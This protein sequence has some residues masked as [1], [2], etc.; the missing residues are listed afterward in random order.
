MNR[1]CCCC[2]FKRSSA[3][4]ESN[5]KQPPLSPASARAVAD[6]ERHRRQKWIAAQ[7]V[8]NE[9]SVVI[10]SKAAGRRVKAAA[11]GAASTVSTAA[12]DAAARAVEAGRATRATATAVIKHHIDS[13]AR[14]PAPT[15][16]TR[17]NPLSRAL[18]IATTALADGLGMDA[19]DDDTTQRT[20]PGPLAPT[21]REERAVDASRDFVGLRVGALAGAAHPDEADDVLG[22]LQSGS[23]SEPDTAGFV[24][25]RSDA[26]RAPRWTTRWLAL[27]ADSS[28]CMRWAATAA[29]AA[30]RLWASS[31][32][33]ALRSRWRRNRGARSRSCRACTRTATPAWT[34]GGCAPT[35]PRRRAWLRALSTAITRANA[36]D[37]FGERRA[38]RRTTVRG[39]LHHCAGPKERW[40]RRW[41]VLDA[42]TS[43]L[44]L[45]LD[46]YGHQ[47]AATDANVLGW[48][49]RVVNRHEQTF[50]VA[51]TDAQCAWFFQPLCERESALE[52]RARDA[53][54][55]AAVLARATPWEI[56]NGAVPMPFRKDARQ[57]LHDA[58]AQESPDLRQWIRA[59]REATRQRTRR[60]G[61]DPSAPGARARGGHPEKGDPEEE[62]RQHVEGV[63]ARWRALQAD[64]SLSSGDEFAG[65]RDLEGESST[66]YLRW[67]DSSPEEEEA[68]E[69]GERERGAV[70]APVLTSGD[71]APGGGAG[72]DR[73]RR[74]LAAAFGSEAAGGGSSPRTMAQRVLAMRREADARRDALGPLE[75]AIHA[76]KDAQALFRAEDAARRRRD[77]QELERFALPDG[78]R[79][80]HHHHHH[81]HRHHHDPRRGNGDASRRKRGRGWKALR[82]LRR[83]R[84]K[85]SSGS[86]ASASEPGSGESSS[87]DSRGSSDA[88]AETR[89]R[90]AG[91][92]AAAARAALPPPTRTRTRARGRG[93]RGR[94][95]RGRDARGRDA[96]G[97]TRADDD[98]I[99]VRRARARRRSGAPAAA[100]LR[101]APTPR[102]TV[103]GLG[104]VGRVLV[105]EEAGD[106]RRPRRVENPIN[107][108]AADGARNRRARHG[109]ARNGRARGRT[110][111]Q[112]PG[113]QPPGGNRRRNRRA[114]GRRARGRRPDGGRG[115]RGA[116]L[117]P[118]R[119][120]RPRGAPRRLRSGRR[121]AAVW[122]E[123]RQG[124]APAAQR[125]AGEASAPRAQEAND[126]LETRGRLETRRRV[127]PPPTP[128]PPPMPGDEDEDVKRD[129]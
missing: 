49:V 92:G 88:G 110:R 9:T 63:M 3:D 43:R 89:A 33:T 10:A 34:A 35:A 90:G 124:E 23:D 102:A 15:A 41:A 45:F 117:G 77:E 14:E 76:F 91:L 31:A 69:G 27:H 38:R 25:V 86:D 21:R 96:R 72:T 82:R 12:T 98:P 103:D 51:P 126:P 66:E 52:K 64:L 95:A 121:E 70:G 113:P 74:T 50:V 20:A 1:L 58:L 94:D 61:R 67:S 83:L 7:R 60:D 36:V 13:V 6:E 19:S 97:R 28:A 71:G 68:D 109:R 120:A 101:L 4:E 47:R 32:C 16:A 105:P 62:R 111:P 17:T 53:S 78:E 73:A 65:A 119:A 114:R 118:A 127:G 29:A 18:D 57:I 106:R 99:P 75:R 59:L 46:R 2:L 129:A 22:A 26:E 122:E 56:E 48:T 100:A 40:K 128:P 107:E 5:T 87:S 79:R 123:R 81:H 30:D 55:R 85:G 44:S 8:F 54:E 37:A 112:P 115:R 116:R 125:G 104:E 93:A 39:Y 80:R 84:G 11:A 108:A 42:A 24:A